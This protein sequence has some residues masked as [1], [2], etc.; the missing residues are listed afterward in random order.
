MRY[1]EIMTEAK[2][3]AYHGTGAKITQF[4]QPGTAGHFFTQNKDYAMGYSGKSSK[5]L[6]DKPK[7]TRNY[8]LT[9]ELT[10]ERMF[11]TKSD[12][13][14]VELYNS[15]FVPT[16]NAIH[17]KYKQPLV[18]E[19]EAGKMVSFI[20]ADELYR[21]FMRYPSQYDG[22]LVDEGGTFGTAI[23]PFNASQIKILKTEIVKF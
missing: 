5:S 10:I 14:A 21:Y 16:I 20:Y 8:L 9:V 15:Q 3:I 12:P 1:A 11:D 19:I 2:F 13:A 7:K 22:M 23:V 18:P 6:I 4:Y 17:A